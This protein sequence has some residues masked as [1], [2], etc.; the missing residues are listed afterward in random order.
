MRQSSLRMVPCS[1]STKP[2]VQAWLGADP[3]EGS[4]VLVALVGQHA[5]RGPAGALERRQDP[6]RREAGGGVRRKLQADLRHRERA[7]RIAGGVLPH[8]P[9]ALQLADVEGVQTD[10]LPGLRRL[11]VRRL[12]ALSGGH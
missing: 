3:I 1:R 2:L 10:E 9:D 8:L 11:H 6:A 7:G 12:T 5:P 4:P